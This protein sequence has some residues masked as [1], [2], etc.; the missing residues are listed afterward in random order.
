MT[1]KVEASNSLRVLVTRNYTLLCLL[2]SFVKFPI[3][4]RCL[5]L[6]LL[7]TD[8]VPHVAGLTPNTTYRVSIR[9]KNIKASPYVDEKSLIRLLEKLS[10][11]TEF[12]TL[13]KGI[14]ISKH[15]HKISFKTAGRRSAGPPDGCPR[16]PRPPGRHGARHMDTRHGTTTATRGLRNIIIFIYLCTKRVPCRS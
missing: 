13:K 5:L 7:L 9:A 14:N 15:R 16:G 1:I 4:S 2:Q 12:R 3:V 11:H 10:A 8:V 6:L